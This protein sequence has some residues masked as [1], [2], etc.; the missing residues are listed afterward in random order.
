M[1]EILKNRKRP[2]WK[3]GTS[4]IISSALFSYISRIALGYMGIET[5]DKASAY[6]GGF[7]ITLIIGMAFLYSLTYLFSY[8]MVHIAEYSTK[9][10]FFMKR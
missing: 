2:V 6:S 3:L 8:F 4:L 1:K 9:L 7:M 10:L 5:S